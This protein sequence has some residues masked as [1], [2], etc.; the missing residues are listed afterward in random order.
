MNAK[1]LLSELLL[2][3]LAPAAVLASLA[4]YVTWANSR[5][6]PGALSTTVRP[7]V[8]WPW[9]EAAFLMT[10]RGEARGPATPAAPIDM[11]LL[12]DV[13]GSMWRSLPAMAQ[14]AREAASEL[15]AAEPGRVRFAL[16][17]FDT[18]AEINT[19]WSADAAELAAGLNRLTPFTGE[20]DTREA[21]V[22][23]EELLR[24]AR[25]GARRVAVFYTDG[26]LDV[27]GSGVCQTPPM[28]RAEMAAAAAALRRGGVELLAVSLP[29]EAPDP[30]LL[31]MTG[32]PGRIFEPGTTADLVRSFRSLSASVA[33]APGKGGLLSHRVDGRAFAVPLGGSAWTLERDGAVALELDHLPSGPATYRHPL[34][35]L[36]A[37]LWRVGI[38][39]ARL[40]FVAAEGGRTMEI[41]APRRPL[42]LAITWWTLLLAA[43]PALLW[44][45]AHHLT[46]RR[47]VED[48]DSPAEPRPYRAPQPDRLPTLPLPPV[49]AEPG[50]P[51]LFLGLGGTGSRALAAARD[52]LAQTDGDSLGRRCRFLAV[53]LDRRQPDGKGG[54]GEEADGGPVMRLVAPPEITAAVDVAVA[55]GPAAPHLAWF[56]A[57]R[58]HDAA[59]ERLDLAPGSRGDRALARLALFRW[60]ERGGLTS[61]LSRACRQVAAAAAGGEAWQIVIFA[62]R[63]GGVGS[64]WLVDCARLA[65]RIGRQLQAQGLAG[66]PEIVGVLCDS[67]EHVRPDN[68]AA[69]A[70]EL[71]TAMLAGAFPSR[72]VYKPGDPLLDGVDGEAPFSWVLCA[73]TSGSDSAAVASQCGSLAAVLGE[74]RPRRALLESA[75]AIAGETGRVVAVSSRVVQVLPLLA[76]QR[77][78]VDLLLRLLGPDVLLDI[79]PVGGGGFAPLAVADETAR[80]QLAEWVASEAPGNLPRQLLAAAGDPGAVLSLL[81]AFE[82]SAAPAGEPLAAALVAGVNRHLRGG[83]EVPGGPWRRRWMPAEGVAVLRLLGRNLALLAAA[84][85]GGAA[86]AA[87]ERLSK[88]SR[89]AE[90]GARQLELWLEGACRACEELARE[91]RA[92]AAQAELVE[93]SGDRVVLQPAEG[94]AEEAEWSRRCLESWLGGADTA[95]PLRERLFLELTAAGDGVEVH[96][97]S[98]VASPAVLADAAAAVAALS[99]V[100]RAL[101]SQLPAAHLDAALAHRPDD[102]QQVLARRLVDRSVPAAEALLVA[103]A[104]NEAAAGSEQGLAG[105][106]RAVPQPP[107]QGP[108]RLATTPAGWAVRRFTLDVLPPQ[109]GGEDCLVA[110]AEQVAEAVRRQVER[111]QGLAV[112]ALP[113]ALRIALGDA[114]AFGRFAAAYRC[115]RIV[116]RRDPAGRD[117]WFLLD[118]DLFLSAGPAG[119]LAQAAACFTGQLA[120]APE[121]HSQGEAPGDLTPVDRWRRSGGRPDADTLVL[122]AIA[123]ATK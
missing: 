55:S 14:A 120:P 23:L 8:V 59:R 54:A 117:Q 115:G 32:A 33:G 93:R 44:L 42:L 41:S 82:R 57:A 94:G 85:Q 28:S 19:P 84:G 38:E 12:V 11:A 1:R 64:G 67:P 29:G 95:S 21:F 2:L 30:L 90:Q 15:A 49:P 10:L 89:L 98:F 17:R 26:A 70:L 122:S 46:R 25:P 31:E 36:A 79:Q 102:E 48:V 91:R 52:E 43:L 3:L 53:D 112:P 100:T 18:R 69:L 5:P 118:R 99:E 13:S 123:Q 9:Q 83:V 66:A 73:A 56:D 61:E 22:R 72:T 47:P 108:L 24:S 87:A 27:C 107:D 96:L 40:T 113:P 68:R 97:R 103:P 116:R 34:K 74:R 75:T 58:Y 62:S 81:A 51:T 39:P 63:D 101:A 92:L 20:N 50:V 109:A 76:P 65:R 105:F 16:I 119:D 78:H 6:Q 121:S 86:G 114:E 37:G 110:A 60:L 88:L 71:E 104:V 77:A 7:G 35:P 4:A 45:P 111:Q 80:R 106:L